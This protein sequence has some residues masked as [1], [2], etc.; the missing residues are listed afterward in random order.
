LIYDL[1]IIGGGLVGSALGRIMA[2]NGRS[3]LILERTTEFQDRIRGEVLMPWGVAEAKKL[4]L[5]SLLLESCATEVAGWSKYTN[6]GKLINCRDLATSS[7]SGNAAMGFYH[8]AMQEVLLLAAGSAGATIKRGAKAIGICDTI[9][10]DVIDGNTTV[11]IAVREAEG[12]CVYEGRLVVGADGRHSNVRK[13]AGFTVDFDDNTMHFSGLL[14]EG[15]D[16]EQTSAHFIID[17]ARGQMSS[18][19]PIGN[20]LFR[21]Y[22]AQNV[23]ESSPTLSGAKRVPDFLAAC[24]GAGMPADWY[25]NAV[26]KGPLATFESAPN[27]VEH[28]SRGNVTL[29][30]DAAATS[31]PI[32]GCGMSLGL[33]DAR[34]LAEQL[35]A[36]DDWVAAGHKYAERHDAYFGAIHRIEYW[37]TDLFLSLGDEAN[38]RR[39]NAMKHIMKDASRMPDLVGLG[40]ESPS[41]EYA[42]ARFYG[43]VDH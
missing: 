1:I 32:W 17:S 12:E 25:L 42:R 10:S 21:T 18:S 8:P 6:T 5:H 9:D 3:V 26:S 36:S 29:I 31:D 40:P 37:M 30:G 7:A 38:S 33:R 2:S 23:S 28:P 39:N 19:F 20:N 14:L 41:D 11:R 13:W 43:E 16:L 34:V 22:F 24:A 27:W 15:L 35:L 4:G